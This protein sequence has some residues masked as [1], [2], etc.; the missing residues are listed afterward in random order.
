MFARRD[1][2]INKHCATTSVSSFESAIATE[3]LQ[4][5][6]ILAID[7]GYFVTEHLGLVPFFSSLNGNSHRHIHVDT[8]S[9]LARCITVTSIFL[10]GYDLCPFICG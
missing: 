8:A 6:Y 2:L 10:R 3:L 7:V 4:C 5:C 9:G 1:N